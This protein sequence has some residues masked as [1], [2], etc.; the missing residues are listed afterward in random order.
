MLLI[1]N[2]RII[3]PSSSLHGKKRDILIKKGKIEEIKTKLEA[4]SNVRK[5]NLKGAC[6]SVGWMDIGTQVGDPGF[7]HREDLESA[8][9]AAAAGGF[10]A[11]ACWPNT[12]PA[13]HSKSEVNYILKN[14]TGGVVRFYPIG[15]VSRDCAGKDLA[16]LFDMH[17]VGAVAFSDGTHTIQDS[18]L[19]MRA[20]QYVKA[21]DGLV[22]NHPQDGAIAKCGQMHE[23]KVSTSLGMKGI[24]ALAEEL[25][26]QRDL[27]LLAYTDSRLHL[28]NISSEGTVNLLK[29][30]K[31]NG[32]QVSASV[33][34]LN[35]IFDDTELVTFNSNFKVLP[36]LREKSDRRALR[37]A[38]KQ[39]TIAVITSN[40]VPLEKEAKN[41]EFAYADFGIISLE[42]TFALCH[43]HLVK[44]DVLSLDQLIQ[45]L[46]YHPRQVL[47]LEIPQIKA[48]EAANLTLFDPN[49]EWEFSADQIF[50]KSENTP[51]LG[52]TFQGKVLGTIHNGLYNLAMD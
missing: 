5:V 6:V 31:A 19:M 2:A 39:G 45:I 1:K 27:N 36:P 7:E 29:Q 44:E 42:T 24:P 50:S 47:G 15:A 14:T 34:V 17:Q 38:L 13:I 30:A 41:L 26:A 48:G 40:H 8:T 37:R 35:L 4:P 43:T 52:S 51:F 25:M 3:D 21:F 10:T 46:A 18:G 9:Q 11:I 16:E 22:M 49:R 28:T 20:L 33:P 12:L 32:L 23:G